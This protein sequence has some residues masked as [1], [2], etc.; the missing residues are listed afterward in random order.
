MSLYR[1]WGPKILLFT[2]TD[3][4]DDASW[5]GPLHVETPAYDIDPDIQ[6]IDSEI[7]NLPASNG[8]NTTRAF[9]FQV[10]AF[11]KPITVPE[12]VTVPVPIPEA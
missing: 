6:H 9:R 8:K 10:E 2:T 12:T 1:G 11:G 5:T 7:V 4:F 3:P